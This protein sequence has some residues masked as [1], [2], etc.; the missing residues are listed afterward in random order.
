M[1]AE[2]RDHAPRTVRACVLT[3]SDTR[4]VDDDVSGAYL[5]SQ[6]EAAGHTVLEYVIVKD[7]PDAIRATLESWLARCDAQ[8][9]LTTGGTGIARRDNTVPVIEDLLEVRLSGFGELFRHLSYPQVGAAAMLSRAVGGLAR[10]RRC[11]IFALPGSLN[12][13]QTAWTGIFQAELPHL[14]FET[15]R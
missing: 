13:V 4:T 3:I 2:H 10:G 9:I 12:A 5:K 7:D 1:T 8:V 14:V 11:L 6:L 15:V